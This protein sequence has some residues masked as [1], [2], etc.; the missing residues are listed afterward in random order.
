MTDVYEQMLVD[1]G[2]PVSQEAMETEWRAINAEEEVGI[3]N[4]S[5]WAPFWRLI[6]A[7]ATKPAMWLVQLLATQVLPNFFLKDATGAWLELLAWAVDLERKKA[8]TTRGILHFTREAAEGEVTVEAGIL[9]AT[10]PINTKI[11]RVRITE[12]VTIPDGV[13][14]AQ[15]PV[16]AEIPGTAHNLGPGY[17][18]VLPEPVSGIAAVSNEAEWITIAGADAESDDSLRL[19]CRNQFSAVGQYH[20]DAAYRADISLFAG[21]QPDFVWFEH[22]APRGPGSANAFVMIDSGQPSQSFVDGIN[23]YIRDQGHHGHGDDMLCFPMPEKPAVLVVTVYHDGVLSGE[24]V[25]ALN[26]AVSD[27]VRFAFREN[28]DFSKITRTMPFSRFS[29][30]T[31]A[32]ELHQQLPDLKSVSF[33]LGDIVSAMEIPTLSSLTVNTEVA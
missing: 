2:I 9:V 32:Y 31:L 7:I 10:P 30:S 33:S 24:R 28:Q 13:I 20:H 1:A 3:A 15:V 12:E 4:D 25:A 23:T 6:T 11:Y 19:R 18:T 26:Q 14:S 22:D 5:E 21:I 17:F 29:F 27:R 16:E 8:A